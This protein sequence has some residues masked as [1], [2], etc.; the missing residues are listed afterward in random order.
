MVSVLTVLM[1]SVAPVGVPSVTIS[2]LLT[3]PS[4]RSEPVMVAE[5]WPAA[6]ES[7]V[8]VTLL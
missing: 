1:V 3:V 4:A 7:G 2:V 6:I 8:A 5:V